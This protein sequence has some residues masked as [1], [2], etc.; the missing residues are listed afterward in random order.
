V[1]TGVYAVK[2]IRRTADRSH[3]PRVRAEQKI[4]SVRSDALLT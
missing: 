2:Q 1:T 3:H 4:V